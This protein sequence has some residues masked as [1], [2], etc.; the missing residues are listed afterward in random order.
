MPDA[1]GDPKGAS[2]PAD[3]AKGEKSDDEIKTALELEKDADKHRIFDDLLAALSIIPAAGPRY[4]QNDGEEIGAE[5]DEAIALA[6]APD[7]RSLPST[8]NKAPIAR[9]DSYRVK[10]GETLSL[11]EAGGVLANDLDP[12]EDPLMAIS[13][14]QN[15]DLLPPNVKIGEGIFRMA[16]DGSFAFTA[17]RKGMVAIPYRAFD[18]ELYSEYKSI[19]FVIDD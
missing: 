12:D 7:A 1:A 9:S 4:P 13:Y 6:S 5:T 17:K 18:G 2:A 16:S 14:D 15:P 8:P 10:V 19:K 3:S 11:A